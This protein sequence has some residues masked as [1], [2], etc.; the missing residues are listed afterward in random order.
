MGRW[1]DNASKHSG[2][3]HRV[4]SEWWID[5]NNRESNQDRHHERKWDTCWG[6]DDKVSENWCEKWSDSSKDSE[7]SLDKGTPCLTSHGKDISSYRSDA[8][9]EG[10]NYSHSW[11]SAS[12]LSRGRGESSHPQ[13][14]PPNKQSPM[15][16]YGRG[17]GENGVSVLSAGHGRVNCSI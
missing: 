13:P 11:R 15:F 8:D 6:P 1:T 16:A 17:K 5:L 7:G 14:L 12:S 3:V 4:P 2:E 10:E 9:M